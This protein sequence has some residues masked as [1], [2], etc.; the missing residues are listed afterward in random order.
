[1]ENFEIKTAGEYSEIKAKAEVLDLFQHAVKIIINQI[2]GAFGNS[3]F[4]FRN[5]DIAESITLQGQDLIKFSI[6][7]CNHYMKNKWHLDYD[8]HKH[9]GLDSSRIKPITN[10]SVCYVDTD[11][12]YVVFD[13]IIESVKEQKTFKDDREAAE[14]ILEIYNYRFKDYLNACFEKYAEFY[15]VK[16][17]MKFKLEKI[18]CG[19][20]FVASKM[21]TYRVIYEDFFRDPKTKASGLPC[22]KSSFPSAAR[23]ILWKLMDICLDKNYSLIV[24]RDLIPALKKSFE[25]FKKAPIEDICYNK[26][27]NGISKYAVPKS[28]YTLVDS[29][30]DAGKTIKVAINNLTGK[31]HM[32]ETKKKGLALAE[33]TDEIGEYYTVQGCGADVKGCLMYNTLLARSGNTKYNELRDGEK[34]K[35]YYARGNEDEDVSTFCFSPG[36]YDESIS[37]PI[38]YELQFDYSVVRPINALLNAMN[39]QSIGRNLKRQII[40]KGLKKGQMV[41]DFDVMYALNKETL[42]YEPVPKRV[43]KYAVSDNARLPE[44]M[45]DEFESFLGKYGDD[46]L[47]MPEKEMLKYISARENAEDKKMNANLIATLSD[48]CKRYYEAA[49]KH[50][51]DVYKFKVGYNK[52]SKLTEISHKTSKKTLILPLEL[53]SS[54]NCADSL[55]NYIL[56]YF[57]DL[58]GNND[59]G[60]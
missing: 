53:L 38:D 32:I 56:D 60:E 44:D 6:K 47:I 31:P 41:T 5:Y 11:S 55:V 15:H 10:E 49:I 20:I 42:Q 27:C 45:Y 12:N 29:L 50:M 1:M 48:D 37:Y 36:N 39:K 22:T 8:L 25:E 35:M 9:L 43:L 46:L 23:D 4:Y 26:N 33:I 24:E 19:G 30:N 17:R 21:Y 18:C 13:Y 59:S 16:N 58:N 14:F 57:D 2:Y 54:M 28:E 3:Y 52:E 51:K 40:V 34:V 7:I